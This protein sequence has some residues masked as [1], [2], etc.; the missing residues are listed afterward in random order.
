MESAAASPEF[1]FWCY[2]KSD[3]TKDFMRYA[4]S[5]RPN[6]KHNQHGRNSNCCC[7]RYAVIHEKTFNMTVSRGLHMTRYCSFE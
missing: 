5:D 4:T 3:D 1:T 2:D 7:F 6:D